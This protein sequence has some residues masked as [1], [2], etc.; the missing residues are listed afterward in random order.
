MSERE[1]ETE[2][3]RRDDG[4][5]AMER[6]LNVLIIARATRVEGRHFS[7]SNVFAETSRDGVNTCES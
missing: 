5:R 1:R 3:A 2:D 7:T 6:S 4:A